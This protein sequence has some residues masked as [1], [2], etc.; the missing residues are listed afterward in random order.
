[1]T[2]FKLLRV[3]YMPKELESGIL[4]V[5]EEF[6]IAGHLCACGC[7]NKVMTPLGPTEWSF[8]EGN[9][10]PTL[11]PSIGNWQWPC[12]SHYWITAGRVEWAGEWSPVQVERGRQAEQ[13]RRRVYF[14]SRKPRSIGFFRRVWSWLKTFFIRS[15]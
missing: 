15:R 10:Q 4:Y 2:E 5:S 6:E 11:R 12:R 3:H 1:V 7:R 14:E 13:E 8:E 9:G